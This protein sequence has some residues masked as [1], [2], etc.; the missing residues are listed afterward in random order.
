MEIVRH[1]YATLYIMM[2]RNG[3]FQWTQLM[4]RRL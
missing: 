4:R 1:I 2:I 3:G